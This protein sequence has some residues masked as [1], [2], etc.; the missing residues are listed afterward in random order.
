MEN[1]EKL[2]YCALGNGP[3]KRGLL[4]GANCIPIVFGILLPT[5]G[6]GRGLGEGWDLKI[7]EQGENECSLHSRIQEDSFHRRGL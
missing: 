1:K 4:P 5:L 6:R 3:W 7:I 2:F